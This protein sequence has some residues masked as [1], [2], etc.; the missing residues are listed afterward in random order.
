MGG[1][2]LQ[3]PATT[4][5]LVDTLTRGFHYDLRSVVASDSFTVTRSGDSRALCLQLVPRRGSNV[6]S[7]QVA[8][9][10]D[11]V[12]F[13]GGVAVRPRLHLSYPKRRDA[14]IKAKAKTIYLSVS[15][16]PER[17]NGLATHN[18]EGAGTPR[19]GALSGDNGKVRAPVIAR[20]ALDPP[21]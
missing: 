7:V 11:S 13:E 10:P 15:P 16:F 20:P 19:Q 9:R 5:T 4:I 3:W 6:D 1:E 18:T 8:M 17:Q 2:W 21:K 12:G 14:I